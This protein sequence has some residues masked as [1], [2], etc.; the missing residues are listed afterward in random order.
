VLTYIPQV[1]VVT[2]ATVLGQEFARP[3]VMLSAAI[4]L[5][6]TTVAHRTLSH[7]PRFQP[8]LPALRPSLSIP[9]PPANIPAHQAR[10]NTAMQVATVRTR[11]ER[12]RTTRPRVVDRERFD[13]SVASAMET[14]TT[15]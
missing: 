8:R 2:E 11:L 6:R 4:A 10:I 1:L 15:R 5:R 13:G 9:L 12:Y 14:T 3:V 7:R